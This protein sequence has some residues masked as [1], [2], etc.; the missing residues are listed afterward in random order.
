MYIRNF[1]ETRDRVRA[2]AIRQIMISLIRQYG[3][4]DLLRGLQHTYR[5]AVFSRAKSSEPVQQR[6]ALLT[7]TVE[8]LNE[9]SH[10]TL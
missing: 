3:L 10:V 1:D 2:F 7:T 5:E 6:E 8:K 4:D 9:V